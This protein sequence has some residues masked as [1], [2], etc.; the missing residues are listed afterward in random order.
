MIHASRAAIRKWLEALL[1]I[2]D[3]P[4]RTAAAFALGVFLG[5]SPPLGL[6]TVLALACAFVLNLN[7]VAVLIGAY[8]NLPW[9]LA[10]YYTVA[11]ALGAKLLGTRVPPRFAAHLHELFDLSLFQSEFWYRLAVLLRPL[12]WPY[13]VGS[14]IGAAILAAIGYRASLAF[15]IAAR[16]HAALHH[17]HRGGDAANH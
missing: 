2:H 17:H 15:V 14:T 11:T 1:H 6:H 3:T 12:L 16:R 7:R 8:A 9:I 4:Q 10:P 5:F 13:V